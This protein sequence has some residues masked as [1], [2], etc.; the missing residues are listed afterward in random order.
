MRDMTTQNRR[1]RMCDR[2]HS[3]HTCVITQSYVWHDPEHDMKDLK[4]TGSVS[5][6]S[7]NHDLVL[8]LACDLTSFLCV[9]WLLPMCDVIYS[10]VWHYSF[11]CVTWPR[12]RHER[13]KAHWVRVDGLCE[14]RSS[15]WTSA[16]GPSREPWGA[17]WLI[18]TCDVINSYMWH[19]SFICVTWLI[20]I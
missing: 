14:P 7:A 3:Y 19:Y 17:T 8:D 1:I 20:H 2:T 4:H 10:Y 18:H 11:I 9:M 15:F 16:S 13:F 5:M 12:G 6:D